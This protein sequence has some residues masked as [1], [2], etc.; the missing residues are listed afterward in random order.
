MPSSRP[1]DATTAIPPRRVLVVGAGPSGLVALKELR[2]VGL[3]AVAVDGRDQIGGIFARNSSVTYDDLYLTTPNM[4]MAF[5]DFPPT[6]NTVKYWSKEEY[7]EYLDR[8]ADH[9]GLRPFIQLETYVEEAKLVEET[10][11]WLVRSSHRGTTTTEIYDY[12]IVATGANQTPHIPPDRL[13]WRN[14]PFV[15]VS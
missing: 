14:P 1:D 5:S 15:E 8:Y 2:A 10:G 9:F 6:E 7:I 11:S 4:F 12:L 3:I 13:W